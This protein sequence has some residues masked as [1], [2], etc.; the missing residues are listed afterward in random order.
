MRGIKIGCKNREEAR[1][2][3]KGC[4]GARIIHKACYGKA[5]TVIL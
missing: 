3:A 4:K 1:Q 2:L 5:W